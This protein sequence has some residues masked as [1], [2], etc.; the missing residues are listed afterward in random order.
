[1]AGRIAKFIGGVGSVALLS[2]PALA[3]DYDGGGEH[4]FSPFAAMQ[5]VMP[6]S[7]T[8]QVDQAQ[9]SASSQTNVGSQSTSDQAPVTDYNAPSAT[10]EP[11][12]GDAGG[13]TFR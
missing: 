10:T 5:G 11:S 8:S 4:R 9:S 7:S 12:A 2:A 3:C 6:A 13:I 1:M